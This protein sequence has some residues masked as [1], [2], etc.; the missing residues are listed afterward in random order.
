MLAFIALAA[1]DAPPDSEIF[2]ADLDLA[3]AR[4]GP[5]RNLTNRPGYDN[6][7]AFLPDGSGFLYVADVDGPTDVFRY[8]FA[9]GAVSRVT[10]TPEAEY[11]PTP[12][13]RGFS[14]VRVGSPDADV[15]PFTESQQL[16][17]YDDTGKAVENL[18]PDVRR[19][20]YH[21]WLDARRVAIVRVGPNAEPPHALVLAD[22]RTGKRTPLAPDA[23]RSMVADGRDL[24]FVDKH[25]DP[26]VITRVTR[27]GKITEVAPM[28]PN[29]PGEGEDAR[30]EDF[31]VLP[32]GTL[33]A[34]H[35]TRLLRWRGS[36]EV[37]AD[38]PE[39][40]GSIKRLAVS[41]DGTRLL[42]VVQR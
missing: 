11:S 6:Q 8:T 10:A 32:D 21:A 36:W 31:R 2:L 22:L 13:D 34:A 37:L 29:D 3:H 30:S 4:V 41:P 35:G 19:V 39:V 33:L 18:L 9:T 24:L 25:A 5:P 26:W 42:F 28:P 40:A 14:A 20:G 1:A 16:W 7:P 15:E 23:G 27:S 17:R 12:L 38:L